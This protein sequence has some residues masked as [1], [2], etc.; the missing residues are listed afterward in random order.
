MK[1]ENFKV[2]ISK[3]KMGKCKLS[4]FPMLNESKK[5]WKS[6]PL[7]RVIIYKIPLN[8]LNDKKVWIS[9]ETENWKIWISKLQVGKS[10]D[11]Q[12]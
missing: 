8:M 10:L 6:E 1:T 3:L 9:D 7:C 2:W 12:C 11:F 5:V 4:G